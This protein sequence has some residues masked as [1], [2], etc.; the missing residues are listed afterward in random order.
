MVKLDFKTQILVEKLDNTSQHEECDNL[1]SCTEFSD[2]SLFKP[3]SSTTEN[4]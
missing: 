2:K 4:V 1:N 3:Y